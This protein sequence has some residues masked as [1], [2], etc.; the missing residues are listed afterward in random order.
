MS[1]L[2]MIDKLESLG[3]DFTGEA[4]V[5]PKG[6]KRRQPIYR[7]DKRGGCKALSLSELKAHFEGYHFSAWRGGCQYAPE[8]TWYYVT[9]FTYEL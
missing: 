3:Y 5:L 6:Y 9:N 2:A 4:L 8:L 1:W 7:I